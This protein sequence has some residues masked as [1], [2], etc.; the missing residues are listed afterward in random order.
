MMYFISKEEFAEKTLGVMKKLNSIWNKGLVNVWKIGATLENNFP[1]QLYALTWMCRSSWAIYK[2]LQ[3][4]KGATFGTSK[5]SS[6]AHPTYLQISFLPWRSVTQ[7]S[8]FRNKGSTYMKQKNGMK[9]HSIQQQELASTGTIEK[10]HSTAAWNGRIKIPSQCSIHR[11]H[12]AIN[13]QPETAHFPL[14]LVTLGCM[15]TVISRWMQSRSI[16]N[17]FKITTNSITT[18][19]L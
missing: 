17:W 1:V 16:S 8:G 11:L 3:P 19:L 15:S 7:R 13:N 10:H 4:L 12:V 18:T 2:P 9:N 14:D 5:S 6:L